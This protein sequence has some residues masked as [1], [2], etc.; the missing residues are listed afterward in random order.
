MTRR[1]WMI[2]IA[3]VAATWIAS[4]WVFPAM[5]ER[6]PTHWNIRGE[7]DGHGPR[8]VGAFVTPATMTGFL[9][10]FA[11]LPWLSPRKFEVDSFRGTGLFVMIVVLLMLAYLHA[12]TLYAGLRGGV[13][14]GR[15]L[16]GGI[17]L[18]MMAL[19][20]V[21]GKIRRNFYIG[22]KTP[23]TL[24]SERVWNDTHRLAAWSFVLGGLLGFLCAVAGWLVLASI[25]FLPMAFVPVL[26]SFWHYKRL[27]ARGGL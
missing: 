20:N 16:L 18:A 4:A 8:W 19:G 3:I 25:L 21:L 13:P 26:Y 2:G 10:L 5:P 15:A 27:E 7:V 12:V 6:F 11:I 14:I 22:V 9:G 23:W 17:F 24:A 1:Y